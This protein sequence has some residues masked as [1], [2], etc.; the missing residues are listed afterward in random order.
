MELSE[1][2]E[3][4]RKVLYE[5]IISKV[6]EEV[7]DL[8]DLSD[9]LGMDSLDI[10]ELIMELEEE[11][12]MVIE[13]EDVERSKPKTVNDVVMFV[14]ILLKGEK[15][16]PSTPV[17]SES[18]DYLINM[19]YTEETIESALRYMLANAYNVDVHNCDITVKVAKGSSALVQATLK[20]KG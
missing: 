9:D 15:P 5:G 2:Q 8:N 7:P 1:V 11:F 18:E 19:V 14:A 4:V 20:R 10:I 13:D 17:S 6:P 16:L 12:G 3:R